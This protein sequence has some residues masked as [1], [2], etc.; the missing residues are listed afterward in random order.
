MIF[1]SALVHL[2]S[3]ELGFSIGVMMVSSWS[4]TSKFLQKDLFGRVVVASNGNMSS[5][6]KTFFQD[7]D[8]C[9]GNSTDEW[10]KGR[11]AGA[12]VSWNYE[13]QGA[14]G[15]QK[16]EMSLADVNK[17]VSDSPNLLAAVSACPITLKLNNSV[18]GADRWYGVG[19]ISIKEGCPLNNLFKS[20]A[21]LRELNFALHITTA[22]IG[23]LLLLGMTFVFAFMHWCIYCRELD[24]RNGKYILWH[25]QMV[26]SCWFRCYM[27]SMAFGAVAMF[28]FA[29]YYA[30][31]SSC[32]LSELQSVGFQFAI[33]FVK[34]KNLVLPNQTHTN[35]PAFTKVEF[36][37]SFVSMIHETNADFALKLDHAIV[38]ET[39]GNSTLIDNLITNREQYDRWVKGTDYNEIAAEANGDQDEDSDDDSKCF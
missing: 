25:W 3:A 34:F 11:G 29:M 8:Q 4:I 5:E 21:I 36:V 19:D 1:P 13:A 7:M 6:Q 24:F 37:R 12:K 16:G 17:C 39:H 15:F 33:L 14:A 9:F 10:L 30:W 23:A 22:N 31:Q 26:G 38:R 28:C 18:W 35:D 27:A 2:F 32:L 20:K